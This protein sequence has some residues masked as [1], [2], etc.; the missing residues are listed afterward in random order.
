MSDALISIRDARELALSSAPR[1]DSERIDVGAALD[2]VLAEDVRGD[3]Q[4]ASVRL[5]G[6]GRLRGDARAGRTNAADRRRVPRRAPADAPTRRRR[7]DPHLDRRSGPG[8]ADAV[9]PQENVAREDSIEIE[10][11]YAAPGSNVR[12]PGEDMH[13]GTLVL[14]AGARAR[15]ASSASRS[16]P[17]GEPCRGA[18]GPGS[19]CSCTG[20]ELRRPGEPL[21]PGEIHN[22]NA[23]MLVALAS[24]CGAAV[25]PARRLS[26]DRAETE[27]ASAQRLSVGRARDLGRGL[28]RAAR[29]RQAGARAP[30]RSR[31][32]SGVSRF[33]RASRPGSGAESGSWFSGCPA[34]R[35][36]PWSR[37]RCSP[38]RC[39][40]RCRA[41]ARPAS[42]SDA[43][44]SGPAVSR[45]RRREQ[46]VRVRLEARADGDAI[47][48]SRTDRRGRTS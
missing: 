15:P 5:L 48:I 33:S 7:G 21:G 31:S 44:C 37:S 11:P 26:D 29:P 27:S 38:G 22:S 25:A 41:R 14:A 19:R 28:G 13:A 2:R 9:I 6:D 35:S 3:G 10:T 8:G 45:N 47:A 16:P 18:R 30:R 24:R 4:R 34:T 17:G 40:W 42:S 46:A 23:P 39:C 1:L 20:D 12:G 43:P 36:R 32:C